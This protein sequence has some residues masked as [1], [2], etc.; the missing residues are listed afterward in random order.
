MHGNIGMVVLSSSMPVL[1]VW[2]AKQTVVVKRGKG[3]GYSGVDQEA[4]KSSFCPSHEKF[5]TFVFKGVRN[6]SDTL[7]NPFL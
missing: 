7:Q 4:K 2:K 3:S 5:H 1:E 6:I